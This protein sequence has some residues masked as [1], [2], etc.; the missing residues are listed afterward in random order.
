M[1]SRVICN[2][3]SEMLEALNLDPD[4]V[5]LVKACEPLDVTIETG[6]GNTLLRN[7]H[8]GRVWYGDKTANCRCA[9]IVAVHFADECYTLC[10]HGLTE[11]GHLRREMGR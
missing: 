8:H 9:E 11:I 6:P 10:Q 2:P 7:I 4:Q 5:D 1:N 3:V